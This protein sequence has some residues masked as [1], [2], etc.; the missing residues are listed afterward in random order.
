MDDSI[1]NNFKNWFSAYCLSYCD[2]GEDLARNIKLKEIHTAYVRNN[3]LLIARSLSLS[4]QWQKIAEAAA[5][6][7]D[8]GRFAQVAKYGTFEDRKS[9]NHG[10]L[11]FKILIE[12]E[13]LKKMPIK[14]EELILTAVKYHNA[15]S[16][17]EKLDKDSILLLKMLR[18]ADKLDIWRVLLDFYDQPLEK[19]ASA[20]GFGLPNTDGYNIEAINSAFNKRVIYIS[21]LKSQ[22]DIRLMQLSWIFDLNFKE[23]YRLL[24]ERD[25]INR[26]SATIS[27]SDEIRQLNIFLHEYV[28]EQLRM[29]FDE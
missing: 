12:K 1:L 14:E 6:F 18:D 10:I 26:I 7:H 24:L 2:K 4:E 9:E 28:K 27:D 15:F 11:G 22:N 25:Y 17:P 8:I 23:T 5:L 3:I 13:I 29:G 16:L 20:P 19:R 21:Q